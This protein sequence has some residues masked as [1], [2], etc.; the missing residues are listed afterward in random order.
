[1]GCIV[2]FASTRELL[3]V[4]KITSHVFPG[5]SYTMKVQFFL[6]ICIVAFVSWLYVFSMEC[7]IG[8]D[9]DNMASNFHPRSHSPPYPDSQFNN[10]FWFLQVCG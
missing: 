1:M 9:M 10:I 3:D 6:L 2:A 4:I 8:H 7:Y 5:A